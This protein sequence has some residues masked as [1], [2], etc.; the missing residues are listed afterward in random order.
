MVQRLFIIVVISFK[1]GIKA[2][3]TFFIDLVPVE[4]FEDFFIQANF[5]SVSLGLHYFSISAISTA[6]F[7]VLFFLV[8]SFFH[9]F[10][11]IFL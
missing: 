5:S 7:T 2:P 8:L 1:F 3:L 9:I 11:R 4:D 10:V 6:L